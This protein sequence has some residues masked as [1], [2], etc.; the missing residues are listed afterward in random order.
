MNN[1]SFKDWVGVVGG[2]VAAGLAVK[3]ERI[4][5]EVRL[6]HAHNAIAAIW[7]GMATK[8]CFLLMPL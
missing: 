3:S 4:N 5:K 2:L 6:S 7:N 1:G 8:S